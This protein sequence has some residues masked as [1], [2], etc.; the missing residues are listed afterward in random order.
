MRTLIPFLIVMLWATTHPV[1]AQKIPG[2][3][4]LLVADFSDRAKKPSLVLETSASHAVLKALKEAGRDRW[5]VISLQEW[6]KEKQ[7]EE[8]NLTPGDV[9]L[10]YSRLGRTDLVRIAREL[11]V[12]AIVEGELTTLTDK[13]GSTSRVAL[14]FSWVDVG[15]LEAVSG[16]AAKADVSATP[17]LPQD[18]HDPVLRALEEA[19]FQI[20]EQMRQREMPS[21]L[22]LNRVGDTITLNRGMRDGLTRGCEMILLRAGNNGWQKVGLVRVQR[23]FQTHSEGTVLSDLGI[24]RPDDAARMLYRLPDLD[25]LVS[26]R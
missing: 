24:V 25:R 7:K 3:V 18:R 9:R 15:L 16:G 22:V 12:D 11:E 21:A 5:E 2:K 19:A 8:K 14:G 6:R 26:S 17:G 4:R 13:R 10:L 23:V 20:V 1:Q